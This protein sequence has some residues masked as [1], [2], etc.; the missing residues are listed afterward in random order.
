MQ[1]DHQ[2]GITVTY[3]RVERC[4]PAD[5]LRC[6]GWSEVVRSLS[7]WVDTRYYRF[8]WQDTSMCYVSFE[9][10]RSKSISCS[11]GYLVSLRKSMGTHGNRSIVQVNGADYRGNN[12]TNFQYQVLMWSLVEFPKLMCF[13]IIYTKSFVING[14]IAPYNHF[15]KYIEWITCA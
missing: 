7:E 6:F 12:K 5:H 13:I 11:W 14:G 8:W 2:I 9:F 3:T 15:I 10:G 1:Q 4:R